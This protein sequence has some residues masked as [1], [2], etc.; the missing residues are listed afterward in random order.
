MNSAMISYDDFDLDTAMEDRVSLR[1]AVKRAT[2]LRQVDDNVFVRIKSVGSDEFVVEEVSASYVYAEWMERL[3][4]RISRF[5][6]RKV[7]R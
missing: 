7:S 4:N 1:E 5:A 2:E 6:R 3:R